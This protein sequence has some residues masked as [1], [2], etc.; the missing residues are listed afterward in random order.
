MCQPID[1]KRAIESEDQHFST[2]SESL[3]LGNDPQWL[4]KALDEGLVG[5]LQCTS[6][7]G[8]TQMNQAIDLITERGN[9][10]C[11]WCNE[12][13]NSHTCDSFAKKKR[14]SI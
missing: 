7:G 2:L 11:V 8:A 5:S 9:R 4:L 6:R 3:D 12:R 1:T 13:Y 14:Y 10:H